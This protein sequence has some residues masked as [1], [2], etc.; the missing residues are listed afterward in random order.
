MIYNLLKRIQNL[1]GFQAVRDKGGTGNPESGQ[2]GAS[3]NAQ[4]A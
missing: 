1:F 2:P 3:C 4:W